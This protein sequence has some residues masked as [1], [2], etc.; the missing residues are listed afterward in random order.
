V[1]R[2]DLPIPCGVFAKSREGFASSEAIAVSDA[3]PADSRAGAFAD[4]ATASGSARERSAGVHSELGHVRF[5]GDGMDTRRR[6][7]Q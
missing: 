4:S 6:S 1:R 2:S 7:V 3:D 5:A